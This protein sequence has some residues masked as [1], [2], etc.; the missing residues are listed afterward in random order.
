M[1]NEQYN[2]GVVSALKDLALAVTASFD[3]DTLLQSIV[4][5]CTRFSNASRGA[6][7]LHSPSTNELVMRAEKGNHPELRFNAKYSVDVDFDAEKIGL[8]AFVFLKGETLVL[9]SPS[10]IINHLAHKGKY[11]D[12]QYPGK[13]KCQSWVGIPLVEPVENTPIGVLKIENTIDRKP[14]IKFTKHEINV[15]KTI[16]DIASASIVKFQQSS[17]RMSSSISS[18]SD[19]LKGTGPLKKKLREIVSTFKRI[20]HADGASIWLLQRSKLV[21]KGGVGHYEGME[22]R[23]AYDINFDLKDAKKVGLTAWIAKSGEMVNIKSHQELITHPQHKGTFDNENYPDPV[24]KKCESFIGAPLKFGDRIIGVIKADYRIPDVDHPEPFFTEEEAQVFSYLAILTAIVVTNDQDFERARKHDSQLLSLYKI[25]SESS[26]LT[27]SNKI[28]WYLLVGLTHHEGIGFNRAILFDFDDVRIPNLHGRMATGPVDTAEGH[29]IAKDLDSGRFDL[30][31]DVYKREFDKNN[32]SPPR[33]KLQVLIERRK[34]GLAKTCELLRFIEESEAPSVRSIK[35]KNLCNDVQELLAELQSPVTDEEQTVWFKL[36]DHNRQKVVGFCDYMYSSPDYYTEFVVNS[37]DNFLN[38]ISLAISK[39]SFKRSEE[40]TRERAWKEFSSTTAHSIGSGAADM[41]GAVKW[42]E[43]LTKEY[44]NSK[45]I[46]TVQR[47]KSTLERMKSW[48][49]EYLVLSSPPQ[50]DIELLDINQLLRDTIAETFS[51]LPHGMVLEKHFGRDLPMI[52][53][54]R[55]RL[56][57]SFTEVFHN[58]M[59]AMEAGGTFQLV[60]EC[61]ENGRKVRI[62]IADTGSGIKQSVQGHIFELGRTGRPGGTGIGLY[63]VAKTVREHGGEITVQS[64]EGEG[65]TFII[66]LPIGKKF[67]WNRVLVV[68]D[69]SNLRYDIVEWIGRKY[70]RLTVDEA[71]SEY[72]A[73]GLLSQQNYDFIITDIRLDEAGGTQ[74]GGLKVLESAKKKNP[75]SKVI[76]VTAHTGMEFK[77]PS[78]SLIPVMDKARSLGADHCISR[79]EPGVDTVDLILAV[80]DRAYI[81]EA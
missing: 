38:Q 72:E 15:F 48:V 33:S 23:A 53:G 1:K 55:R 29:E 13:E 63:I 51:E 20:S 50:M 32:E 47:C 76:V 42:I 80:I 67:L 68:E 35:F 17:A 8:T 16:A 77:E 52:G 26:S 18:L 6:L 24:K 34:I 44:D 14:S 59:K 69:R 36:L 40:E 79:N 21:C 61:I 45:L 3:L 7:F 71:S 28:L 37:I 64:K 65:A 43:E 19:A 25:G 81:M 30:S 73:E 60:T 74:F 31:L 11:D 22:D 49:Q 9:N 78:G 57:Y 5:T 10:A 54:D 75:R 12:K 66:D 4:E 41:S 39:L 46:S 2:N 58:G 70:A 56:Q 27:D 62:T